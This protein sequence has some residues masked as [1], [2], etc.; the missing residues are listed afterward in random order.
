MHL[1]ND[2]KKILKET[3]Q[4]KIDTIVYQFS[5]ANMNEDKTRIENIEDKFN[6]IKLSNKAVQNRYHL[7][8]CFHYLNKP[9]EG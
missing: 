6:I 7:E 9:E 5:I 8:Q 1:Y 4:S 3:S 2:L